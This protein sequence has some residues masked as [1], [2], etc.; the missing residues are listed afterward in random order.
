MVRADT[1][2]DYEIRIMKGYNEG[3]M[4][5]L[6]LWF[7]L[8]SSAAPL[9]EIGQETVLLSQTRMSVLNES[10]NESQIW[11]DDVIQSLTNLL[12]P[13][14]FGVVMI[15]GTVGNVLVITVVSTSSYS[16]SE[17]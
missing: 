1:L 3:L 4:S 9:R 5:T 14:L 16:D 2:S 8:H 12:V 6:V 13:L 11:N 15:V 10:Y 17:S 7:S